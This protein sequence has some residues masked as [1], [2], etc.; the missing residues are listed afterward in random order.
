MLDFY[1][2]APR[3]PRPLVTE[4]IAV[5]KM[6]M[7]MMF[8]PIA[9]QLHTKP[10]TAMPAGNPASLDF[11]MAIA[12]R[13]KPVIAQSMGNTAHDKKN[14]KTRPTMPHTIPA[15]PSP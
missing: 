11:F 7:Q 8:H 10:A 12:D 14:A 3:A 2:K 5:Q 1:H 9:M 13:T 15:M 4:L 6:M